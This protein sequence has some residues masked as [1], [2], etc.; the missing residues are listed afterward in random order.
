M[1]NNTFLLPVVHTVYRTKTV[2][3][4]ELSWHSLPKETRDSYVLCNNLGIKSNFGNDDYI[5]RLSLQ[6]VT[7]VPCFPVQFD[8]MIS[9]RPM[10]KVYKGV[11]YSA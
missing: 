6:T 5:C 2:S 4:L 10:S 11:R 1:R 9:L 8:L 3:A 7:L